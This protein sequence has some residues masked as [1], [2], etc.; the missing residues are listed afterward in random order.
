MRVVFTP[1]VLGILLLPSFVLAIDLHATG[2]GAAELPRLLAVESDEHRVEILFELPHLAS[3][4]LDVDGSTYHL[5][6]VPGGSLS[7]DVGEP[8]LPTFT[9]L[10]AIPDGVGVRVT[11][12]VEESELLT[13]FNVMPMQPDDVQAFVHDESAYQR[14]GFSESALASVGAPAILRDLRVVTLTFHPVDYNPA[15]GTLR[16]TRRMR[17]EVE[18][19]GTDNRNSRRSERR[20]LTPSFDRL[21]RNTVINYPG[22]DG[23]RD[24]QPTHGTYLVICPDNAGVIDRLQPLLDWRRRQGMPVRLATTTETGADEQDIKAFIQTAYDSWEAPP[25]FIV[26]AGDANGA[27]PVQTWYES[28]SGYWG[29]GD[30]PFAQLERDDVL[31]DAHVGRLSYSTLDLLELIINNTVYYESAPNMDD[32]PDWFTRACLAGDPNT[33]SGFSPVEVQRWIKTRLREIGYTEIDTVFG[34]NMVIGMRNALNRG[35]TIFSYRGF[36]GMSGWT[37]SN[38]SQLTNEWKMPFCVVVTCE[39]GSFA[40]GTSRSEGFLRAGTPPDEPDGGVGAI[41]TATPG[42]HT[43]YNNCMHYGIYRG[44][45]W[46]E[47]FEMGAA[48]T[49]GK[50][51]M[52]M[53]YNDRL[54]SQVLIYSH[55]NNLMGDPACKVWTGYPT[56]MA[57]VAPSSVPVGSNA[58]SVQVRDMFLTP[59]DGARVCAWKGEET[60]SVGTT[61]AEG[62]LELPIN[63]ESVGDILLTAT[64]HNHLPELSTIPVSVEDVYVGYAS[65]RI[66]DDNIGTSTG[67]GNEILNPGESVELPV[68]LRNFGLVEAPGV[69]ATLTTDDPYVTIEDDTETFGDIFGAMSRWSEDD[70]DFTLDS[71]C[72]HGHTLRFGLDIVSGADEWHSLIEFE[73]VSADLTVDDV[74]LHGAGGNGILDPGETVEMSVSLRNQ[75]GA[76]ATNV[77]GTLTS[78]S[79]FVTVTDASGSFGVIDVDA[80]SENSSDRFEISADP[81]AIEGHIA[82][83]SL[84]TQFSGSV[85]DTAFALLTVGERSSTDPV[86]PDGY[87]YYAFDNTDTGYWQAPVYDWVEIAPGYGGEGTEI[88]LG[89]YGEYQDA[90]RGVDLPFTFQYYGQAYDRVTVCSNGWLAMGDTYLSTYRNWTIPGAAGPAA[91][92]APFWDDL[93][94]SGGG[95]AYQYYDVVNH[96]WIVEWSGFRNMYGSYTETFE[97]I[98]YDPAHH[99]TQT[100]DGVIEFQYED[101]IVTDAIN[102]YCTV[103]I[104]NADQSD[105]VLYTFYNLYPDGAATVQDGRAI[106]FVPMPNPETVD[107]YL[108]DVVPLTNALLPCRPNPV[109]PS[110]MIHYQVA[111][112]APVR[113]RLYDVAGR[114][115]VN[116]VEGVVP[117]GT[118]RVGWDGR[119]GGGMEVGSGVYFVRLQTPDYSEVQRV[120]VLR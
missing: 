78:L 32:D 83:L 92:I 14:D 29:E 4:T 3:E 71:A 42:T 84:V 87:G 116:L 77:F 7:G 33:P 68:L 43:R 102:H 50:L 30:H 82:T 80:T 37:N 44:L 65:S 115:V 93:Y 63:A 107:A 47:Q 52:Y 56:Q 9:R 19:T 94:Q 40:S 38:T 112:T 34:G 61:D 120:T 62:M 89:D 8:A 109:N 64:K 27:Y 66:D 74:I 69:V 22:P 48:L 31:A 117:A 85:V 75:G 96:R 2:P 21:Y 81:G 98:L 59:V 119:D 20:A 76:A 24:E 104:E 97:A 13:G 91:M 18:F 51:E 95:K 55:W 79:P 108:I 23:E 10:V 67:N 25:E 26:L 73:V 101:V 46:E 16:V 45:L 35:D 114:H 118:H 105:G 103:G 28:A 86:G 111:A 49:R 100:G 57:I 113:V 58:L 99:P 1:C 39:T 15:Q 90:S 54:P 41:G 12:S 70:Y 6:G 110:T 106:R 11:S 88:V 53:N 36:G 5:L 72:P 17:V 60:Y